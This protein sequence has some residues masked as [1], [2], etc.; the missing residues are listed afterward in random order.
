MPALTIRGT[1]TFENTQ[2]VGFSARGAGR[3][4][5]PIAAIAAALFCPSAIALAQPATAPKETTVYNRPVYLL[6]ND[7]LELAVVKQGGS[8]LRIRIQGDSEGLSPFGNPEM[9]PQVPEN[10]KLQ[11]A[12]VG[13]FVCVDGFGSPS[14]E[15]RVAGLAMHGEAYLQP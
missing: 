15:E 8:M 2:R 14:S 6:T 11:G 7:K 13:H 12:M 5:I 1:R 9:V 3:D 10:R 4:G